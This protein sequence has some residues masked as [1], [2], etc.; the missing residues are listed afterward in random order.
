ME[1]LAV[2]LEPHKEYIVN[3]ASIVTFCHFL[4]GAV[5]CNDIRKKKSTAGL[6][7]MPFLAGFIL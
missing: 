5:I 1:Q 6:S 3:A 4:S 2:L 7:V